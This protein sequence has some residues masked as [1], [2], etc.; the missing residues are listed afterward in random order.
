MTPKSLFIIIIRIIGLYFLIGLIKIIPELLGTLIM[1]I[2]Q[3]VSSSMTW[4]I[5][6]TLL[7]SL[8][9]LLVKYILF[10]PDKVVDKLRLSRNFDVE[11]FEFNIHRSTV[12]RIAVIFIGGL[13]LL[14][15]FV[16]LVLNLLSYVTTK[17]VSDNN[18]NET[19]SILSRASYVEPIEIIHGI[20]MTLI[21]YFLV[22]NSRLITNFIEKHRKAGNNDLDKKESST[23]PPA[24]NSAQ[25][26][27]PRGST[28]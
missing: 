11:K 20:L 5:F 2:Q 7:V 4:I 17:K 3:D 23:K 9:L 24:G 14:E 15:Y 16:P 18:I 22:T 21:G 25:P 6:A 8:Y 12:I 19:L 27:S 26:A 28:S 13:T 10:N 1:L